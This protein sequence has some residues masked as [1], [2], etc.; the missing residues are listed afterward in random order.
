MALTWRIGEIALSLELGEL[1]LVSSCES[2][3]GLI[4]L[5]SLTVRRTNMVNRVL[6]Y[7]QFGLVES[8][9]GRMVR[10]MIGAQYR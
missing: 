2:R 6:V 7:R 10:V 1:L 4:V 9:P 5:S 8:Q 3:L